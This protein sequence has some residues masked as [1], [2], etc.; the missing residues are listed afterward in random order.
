[1][2]SYRELAAAIEALC[3]AIRART[4]SPAS[5][6]LTSC[7][8]LA[9]AARRGLVAESPWTP[10]EAATAAPISER[11]LRLAAE[12]LNLPLEHVREELMDEIHGPQIFINSRYQV[13][14]RLW[15]P[16]VM[17][18]SIKRLD[19]QP[20]RSWRDLQRIKNEL[21]GPENEG[22]ELFPAESRLIDRAN[23]FHLFVLTD[24]AARF[25]FGYKHTRDVGPAVG[26]G[27]AQEPFEA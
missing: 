17:Y 15:N 26:V 22:V 18:L 23:Q 10:F 11:A 16:D 3:R 14:M 21:V 9:A 5:A 2:A 7:E 13:A 12:R 4:I 6:L 27:E 8:T 20:T 1:M 24:P 19:Q 25:P